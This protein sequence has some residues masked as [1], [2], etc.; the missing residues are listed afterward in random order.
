LFLRSVSEFHHQPLRVRS[1][2]DIP[3]RPLME[4]AKKSG[5]SDLALWLLRLWLRPEFR[6]PTA[7]DAA[8]Q[9]A[10]I[11]HKMI[12]DATTPIAPDRRGHYGQE[13]DR[14]ERTDEWRRKLAALV[15]ELKQ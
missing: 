4:S 3:M 8:G 14:P 2:G 7:E 6:I 12:I 11:V 15:K 5:S 13:L 10:G 9:P 1:S